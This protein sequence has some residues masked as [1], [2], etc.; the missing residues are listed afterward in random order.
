MT[1]KIYRK[2]TV[3]LEKILYNQQLEDH[4]EY[5]VQNIKSIFTLKILMKFSNKMLKPVICKH[6][7]NIN[8]NI[9]FLTSSFGRRRDLIK[10]A[11]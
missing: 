3:A 5:H 9:K 4:Q 11:C 8:E 1:V 7:A 6:T 2:E 10:N